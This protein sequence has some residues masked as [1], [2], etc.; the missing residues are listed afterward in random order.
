ML[1]VGVVVPHTLRLL[2]NRTAGTASHSVTDPAAARADRHERK[3]PQAQPETGQAGR[4][5]GQAG[6]PYGHRAPGL[7]IPENLAIPFRP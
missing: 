2:R 4:Q 3:A 1:T 7:Q 5:A 6:P